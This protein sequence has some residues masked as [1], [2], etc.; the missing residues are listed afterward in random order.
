M[1]S[2]KR[3]SA[4]HAVK[5]RAEST[6]ESQT[7]TT[8]TS[9]SSAIIV[10]IITVNNRGTVQKITKNSRFGSKRG[11]QK[12]N[13]FV[14]GIVIFSILVLLVFWLL[15]ARSKRRV[16][17]YG[18][19]KVLVCVRVTPCAYFIKTNRWRP[20]QS[21]PKVRVPLQS[22]EAIN[23]L[24]SKRPLSVL[25]FSKLTPLYPQERLKMETTPVNMVGRIIDIVSPPGKGQRGLIVASTKG[26]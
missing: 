6:E 11:S 21:A 23:G 12:K 26:W 14:A 16:C 24:S 17:I 19:G 25:R 9:V 4:V 22:V 1:R 3:T 18:S 8:I 5:D 13:S 15:L 2:P 7:G 20:S 10:A